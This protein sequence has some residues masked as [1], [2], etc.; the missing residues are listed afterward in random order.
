MAG[1]V[2]LES[3]DVD[4]GGAARQFAR[5]RGPF[6]RIASDHRRTEIPSSISELSS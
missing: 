2:I 5:L 1:S 3:S 4:S 6:Y